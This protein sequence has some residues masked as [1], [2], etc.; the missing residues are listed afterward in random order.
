MFDTVVWVIRVKHLE[1]RINL[2]FSFRKVNDCACVWLVVVLD[3]C[4]MNRNAEPS[5]ECDIQACKIAAHAF[6]MLEDFV[7]RKN[8]ALITA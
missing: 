2:E 4:V 3:C 1:C 5:T 7:W 6:A 8:V